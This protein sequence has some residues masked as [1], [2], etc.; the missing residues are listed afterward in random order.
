MI[1][2]NAGVLG[3]RERHLRV[4]R[5]P[6]P[7]TARTGWRNTD[8]IAAGEVEPAGVPI[9][10]GIAGVG[11]RIV[12]RQNDRRL[13]VDSRWVRNGDHWT[14]QDVG[15]DGSLI[16]QREGTDAALT[17]PASYIRA[18]VE[19]GYAAT[20]HRAQGRTVDTAHALVDAK[21]TRETLY[22][23]ATRGRAANHL[24]VDLET[25]PD[26]DTGHEPPV[27]D[28]SEI[29]QAALRRTSAEQSAHDSLTSADLV[30]TTPIADPAISN[31]LRTDLFPRPADAYEN[32]SAIDVTR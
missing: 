11:D 18:H 25:D 27:G 14:I 23:A 31:F 32:R 17:L 30:V 5:Y 12:T 8:R 1:W 24:Y 7:E 20:A 29:L 28:A 26:P 2:P 9:H 6:G 16:V 3:V 4:P 19:L 22:V 15:R 10:E 13:A 21:S